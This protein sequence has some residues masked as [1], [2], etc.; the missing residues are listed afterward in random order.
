MKDDILQGLTRDLHQAMVPW[1]ARLRH[2][3]G[4]QM[5]DELIADFARQASLEASKIARQRAEARAAIMNE[6][7]L[8]N[9][10]VNLAAWRARRAG[11]NEENTSS[12]EHKMID[13]L[14]DGD[15]FATLASITKTDPEDLFREVFQAGLD[16]MLRG[17]GVKPPG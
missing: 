3:G 9:G 4:P 2:I 12:R 10:A 17:H 15:G 13:E 8:P 6:E 16:A 5:T 7:Q 14:V 1:Q 11:W